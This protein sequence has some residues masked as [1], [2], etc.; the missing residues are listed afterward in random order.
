[1]RKQSILAVMGIAMTLALTA[2]GGSGAP[3]T[4]SGTTAGDNS[5]VEEVKDDR[6]DFIWFKANLPE[7][8]DYVSSVTMNEVGFERDDDEAEWRIQIGGVM[9][10]SSTAESEQADRIALDSEKYAAA[11]DVTIGDYT[12]K[13]VTFDWSSGPSVMLYADV[14]DNSPEDEGQIKVITI[15][16]FGLT[17]DNPVLVDFLESLEFPENIREQKSVAY[18]VDTAEFC[19]ENNLPH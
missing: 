5:A 11:D 17:V 6:I 4:G 13:V 18:E 8:T 15:D 3:A 1:M 14:E 12:W 2:C 9:S 19:E 10:S 16:A 7:G